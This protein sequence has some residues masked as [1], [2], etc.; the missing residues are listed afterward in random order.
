MA[1]HSSILARE[2][3][4]QRGLV[5]YSP[6]GGKESETTEQLYMAYWKSL[7]RSGLSLCLKLFFHLSPGCYVCLVFSAVSSNE[8][9][10]LLLQSFP[11]RF[12]ICSEHDVPC[13]FL[14][15]SIHFLGS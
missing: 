8:L 9:N 10:S 14:P 3:H 11:I 1:T 4:G 15:K 6:W 12:S 13:L 2:S 5:G 7:M